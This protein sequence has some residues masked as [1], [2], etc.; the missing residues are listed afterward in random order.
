M[1]IHLFP[2]V[3]RFSLGT[4]LEDTTLDLLEGLLNTNKLPNALK[5][6]AL[7]NQNGKLEV[8]RLLVRLALET[9]CIDERK[10]ITLQGI[11]QE[12]GKMLGGW[13]RS[14]S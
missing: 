5:R 12:I 14:L 4:R 6:N 1:W 11:L 13:M 3:E 8:L 9:R 2:K 7:A 10:Y